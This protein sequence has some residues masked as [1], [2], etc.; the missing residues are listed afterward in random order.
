M[1][2]AIWCKK[3]KKKQIVYNQHESSSTLVSWIDD[4]KFHIGLLNFNIMYHYEIE[5][6]IIQNGGS[7]MM[8]SKS[9]IVS[10]CTK[11]YT[12]EL[13][14]SLNTNSKSHFQNSE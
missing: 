10:F 2:D 12:H 9:Q 14:V 4:Y 6:F 11:I 3:N 5:G 1:T 8:Y 7:N 13:M